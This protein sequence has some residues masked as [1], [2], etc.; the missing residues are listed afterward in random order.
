MQGMRRVTRKWVKKGSEKVILKTKNVLKSCL[1][2]VKNT[3]TP[4]F[5]PRGSSDRF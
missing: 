3:S 4:E 2:I 5:E 1:G